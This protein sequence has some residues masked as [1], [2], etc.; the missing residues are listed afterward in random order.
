M[1][2]RANDK[3]L[4][5]RRKKKGEVLPSPNFVASANANILTIG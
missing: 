1:E 2:I 5:R 4:A 3:S